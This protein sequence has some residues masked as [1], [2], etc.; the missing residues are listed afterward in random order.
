METKPKL[1]SKKLTK[2]TT[3]QLIEVFNIAEPTEEEIQE[4]ILRRSLIAKVRNKVFYEKNKER[5]YEKRVAKKEKDPELYKE[6]IKEYSKTYYAK[7]SNIIECPCGAKYKQVSH[8]R[9]ISSDKHLK[10]L[11]NAL[12]EKDKLQN[13][14]EEAK[15]IR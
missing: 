7:N 4:D 9:H 8:T 10:Y 15:P 6:K 11:K 13:I 14:I 12:L 3:E 1:C 5:I 2:L